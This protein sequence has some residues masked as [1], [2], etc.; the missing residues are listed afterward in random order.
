MTL[1]L[2]PLVNRVTS[3]L[4]NAWICYSAILISGSITN[5]L[6]QLYQNVVMCARIWSG[7]LTFNPDIGGWLIYPNKVE[8][9]IRYCKRM[10]SISEW[11]LNSTF[12]PGRSTDISGP[13]C[14]TTLPTILQYVY[15]Y[16]SPVSLNTSPPCCS[17][18]DHYTTTTTYYIQG[19]TEMGSFTS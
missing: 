14:S 7:D 2:F 12:V 9:H 19:W 16:I 10:I 15:Y 3:Q 6:I 18:H 4:P 1:F 5:D 13:H 8:R 11:N 17:T